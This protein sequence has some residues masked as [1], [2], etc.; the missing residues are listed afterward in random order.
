MADTDTQKPASAAP[1]MALP[2]L[3]EMQHWTFVMGRAQQLM[4][5]FITKQAGEAGGKIASAAQQ[6][7]VQWPMANIFPDPAKVAQ[8]QV[9]LWT[10]GMSIWQTA[11]GGQSEPS[12]LQQQADKD[13]R[14]NAPQWR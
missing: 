4:L 5:E 1:A 2:S 6:P 14:F 9:D 3:E 10:Q 11:L 8:A 13:K 12:E 7:A